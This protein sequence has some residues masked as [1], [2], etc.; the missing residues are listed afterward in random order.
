MRKSMISRRQDAGIELRDVEQRAEQILDGAERFVDIL[1]QLAVAPRPARRRSAPRR[2]AAP[3]S[4][5]AAGRGWPRRGTWSCRDWRARRRSWR[6]AAPPDL[7]PLGDLLLQLLVEHGQ[8]GG[9]LLDAAL[10]RLVG[11]GPAPPRCDAIGD[12]AEGED[13]ATI[14]HGVALRREV[15]AAEPGDSSPGGAGRPSR[16]A[17]GG[18]RAPRL[19]RRARRYRRRKSTKRAPLSTSAA[20]ARRARRTRCSRRPARNRGRRRRHALEDVVE[21]RLQ[22]VADFSASSVSRCC[23]SR[24]FKSGHVGVD[25]DD[26]AVAV[27]CSLT[28]IQ[29]PSL[30][31]WTDGPCAPSAGEPQAAAIRRRVAIGVDH[32]LALGA[33]A[34]TSRKRDAGWMRSPIPGQKLRI[35]RR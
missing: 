14:R 21:R 32:R 13:E 26:A 30:S 17:R 15:A 2:R 34:T 20:A 9:A 35:T 7:A 19:A 11:L 24:R 5:A 12:V 4:T 3:R 1:E 22:Q 28:C 16:P 25:A 10:Q 8:R 29:R 23:V 33:A 31:A 6:P 18:G 27:R